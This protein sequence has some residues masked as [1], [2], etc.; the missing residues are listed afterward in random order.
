MNGSRTIEELCHRPSLRDIDVGARGAKWPIRFAR[1]LLRKLGL[2]W[3]DEQ[4]A[5]NRAVAEILAGVR[6]EL[7]SHHRALVDLAVEASELR[8]LIATLPD[9]STV[10]S[11]VASMAGEFEKASTHSRYRDLMIP[12][13]HSLHVL[14]RRVA[15]LQGKQ[16]FQVVT[17]S[18][19]EAA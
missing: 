17:G 13:L 7:D 6:A 15:E 14:E 16:T 18:T 2:P 12:Y 11:L 4:S 19:A 3:I 10:R 8:K 9:E 5:R 1:R